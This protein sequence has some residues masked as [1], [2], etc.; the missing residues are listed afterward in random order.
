MA[1]ACRHCCDES[2]GWDLG[3]TGDA[4]AASEAA[5]GSCGNCGNCGGADCSCF[6][7][8]NRWCERETVRRRGGAERSRRW[9]SALAL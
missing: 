5:N 1:E 7:Q 8:R 2:G 3:R 9:A 6:R 4:A